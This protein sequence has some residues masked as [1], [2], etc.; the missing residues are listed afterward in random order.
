MYRVFH[1]S[2][3]RSPGDFLGHHE[4]FKG[5]FI[6]WTKSSELPIGPESPRSLSFGAIGHYFGLVIMEDPVGFIFKRLLVEFN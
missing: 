1:N 6:K 2:K 5:Q 4:T 3:I